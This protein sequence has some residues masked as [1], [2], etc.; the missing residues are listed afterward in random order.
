[1]KFQLI[2]AKFNQISENLSK[3]LE[4]LENLNKL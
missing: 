1:M 3:F 2:L 4:I